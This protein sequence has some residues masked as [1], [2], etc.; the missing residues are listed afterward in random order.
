[1]ISDIKRDIESRF[2]NEGLVSAFQQTLKGEIYAGRSGEDCI[3]QSLKSL[4]K[5]F[6]LPIVGVGF[7]YFGSKWISGRL[8]SKVEGWRWYFKWPV[9]IIVGL[10]GFALFLGGL[11]LLSNGD[12]DETTAH[13]KKISKRENK[14][15]SRAMRMQPEPSNTVESDGAGGLRRRIDDFKLKEITRSYDYPKAVFVTDR[16]YSDEPNLYPML[17]GVTRSRGLSKYPYIKYNRQKPHWLKHTVHNWESNPFSK[18]I[19]ISR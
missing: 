7:I 3:K 9:K 5:P 17:A 13:N 14:L 6:G 1:M 11:E 15:K 4:T 19:D 8:A 18:Q 2:Q 12:Y 10:G 16:A